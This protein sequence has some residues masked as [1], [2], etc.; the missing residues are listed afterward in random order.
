MFPSLPKRRTSRPLPLLAAVAAAWMSLSP[1]ARAGSEL[2]IRFGDEE[3]EISGFVD[4]EASGQAL[5]EAMH[6]A[7]PDL[8]V[9]NR[10]LAIDP[11]ARLL[12]LDLLASLITEIGISTHDG[13][14][15]LTDREI[16]LSGLTDSV[17]TRSALRV[18]LRALEDDRQVVNHIC[19]V[20]SEDLPD[21]SI[22]LSTGKRTRPVLDIGSAPPREKPFRIPGVKTDRLPR[23]VALLSDMHRLQGIEPH[24]LRAR[25]LMTGATDGPGASAPAAAEGAAES[26]FADPPPPPLPAFLEL[27][28]PV[29]FARNTVLLQSGQAGRFEQIA[30]ELAKEEHAGQPLVVRALKSSSG[31]SEFNDWLCQRRADEVK[32]R[33]AK[34]GIDESLV[35]TETASHESPV[36][37]GRVV[38]LVKRRP[39]EEESETESGTEGS[40]SETMQPADRLKP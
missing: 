18:R 36:D 38:L 11:E 23:L 4:S 8:P 5:A 9:V 3:A 19:I 2:T 33:L 20:P 28:E 35:S 37:E 29:L 40:P 15:R 22:A 12:P 32:S 34:I 27:G 30:E 17:L 24:P 13:G 7:R 31:S 1:L 39:P 10:G 6:A 16:R 21:I 25:P 14:I 26:L